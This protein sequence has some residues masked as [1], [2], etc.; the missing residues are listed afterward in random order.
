MEESVDQKCDVKIEPR[1][2]T[3]ESG[4][5]CN[6]TTWETNSWANSGALVV[7]EHAMKWLILVIRLMN[8]RIESMP[9]E[10]RRSVMKSHE[11]PFQDGVG[12]G[13]GASF[14]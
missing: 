11:S 7:L 13:S 8:T 2:E 12:T 6:L 14:P 1:S 10:T 5:P 4:R 9:F 3:I